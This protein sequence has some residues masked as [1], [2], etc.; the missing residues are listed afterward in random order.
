VAKH[1]VDVVVAVA[2]AVAVAC[3]LLL[4]VDDFLLLTPTS[5][6]AIVRAIIVSVTMFSL[7][8]LSSS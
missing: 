3:E 1:L 4:V 5:Q 2:V 7:I 8:N 6:E